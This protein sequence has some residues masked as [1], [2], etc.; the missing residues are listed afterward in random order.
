MPDVRRL[1]G[2]RGEDRAAAFLK[3]LGYKILARQFNTRFGEIDLIAQDGDEIVFVEVKARRSVDFG[4]P[5]ES[6]TKKKLEKIERVGEW[7]LKQRNL[8][9][10]PFRI[11]V[12]AIEDDL[13]QPKIHHIKAVGES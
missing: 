9:Y 5:E 3:A 13:L 8:E 12:I 7:Y 6:V 1:F 10:A 4:Y 11:D 2:N